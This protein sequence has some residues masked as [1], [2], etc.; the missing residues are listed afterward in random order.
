MQKAMV[1]CIYPIYNGAKPEYPCSV[2]LGAFSVLRRENDQLSYTAL[3]STSIRFSR[4]TKTAMCD[5]SAERIGEIPLRQPCLPD[6]DAIFATGCQGARGGSATEC[7]GLDRRS[8]AHGR[9]Q[10][11]KPTIPK[12][13]GPRC[14]QAYPAKRPCFLMT[15]RSPGA[16]TVV[17]PVLTED[18]LD[19]CQQQLQQ[20][21]DCLWLAP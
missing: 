12:R 2:F 6:N 15:L 18:P 5:A 14:P 13:R 8:S 10:L 16:T 3:R 7:N 9:Q 19:S 11:V 17:E 1:K 21:Q 4:V 20:D